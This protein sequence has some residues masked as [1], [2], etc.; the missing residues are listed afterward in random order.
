ML[1]RNG[2]AYKYFNPNNNR[3]PQGYKLFYKDEES[4][5]YLNQRMNCR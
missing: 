1:E 3:L 2:I 5:I 4:V